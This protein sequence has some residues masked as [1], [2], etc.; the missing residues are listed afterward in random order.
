[1][2][3]DDLR[4]LLKVLLQLPPNSPVPRSLLIHPTLS[5]YFVRFER[6]DTIIYQ[7][8]PTKYFFILLNGQTIIMN[9]ISWSTNDI[10]NY[11][12]PPHILG[13]S[14][15]LTQDEFYNAFV[16]ADTKCLTFKIRAN[17]FIQLIQSD[18]ELCYLVLTVMGYMFTLNTGRAE[19]RRIFPPKD[20][21]G[22][23]LY[24]QAKNT[25]S[26]TCPLTHNELSAELNINLRTLYRYLDSLK[27]DGYLTLRRGKI[28]IESSH[29]QKLSERYGK[30]HL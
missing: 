12:Q 16:V 22:Y 20:C 5:R 18:A 6:G 19:T 9:L 23:Y 26:Y 24:V 29:F 14:E 8:D 1:M 3:K 2:P 7:K 13:L 28:V 11:V 21:V 10:I 17:E 15:Y 25:S 30:V 27:E 4:Q